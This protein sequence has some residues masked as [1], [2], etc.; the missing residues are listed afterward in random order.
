MA[1]REV[2]TCHVADQDCLARCVCIEC[3]EPVCG[4]CSSIRK[5]SYG[6]RGRICNDCQTRMDGSSERVLARMHRRANR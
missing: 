4:N 5:S 1:K 3:C 6:Q 2:V